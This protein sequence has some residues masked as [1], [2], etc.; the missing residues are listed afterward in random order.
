[1]LNDSTMSNED[2]VL[3]DAGLTLRGQLSMNKSFVKRQK[4]LQSNTISQETEDIKET[5][6]YSF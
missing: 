5:V 6:G 2:S 1:M 3:K 4:F